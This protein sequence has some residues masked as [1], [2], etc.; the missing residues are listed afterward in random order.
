MTTHVNPSQYAIRN[1]H[2]CDIPAI[3]AMQAR[4]MWMLGGDFYTQ[5]EIATFM[6]A[7]GT[8]DDAIVLEGHFFV[9]EDLSGAILASGGWS[10]AKPG[11]A[12]ALPAKEPTADLPSVRSVFVDP[13]VARRGIGRTI[14]RQVEEDAIAHG[15]RLLSLT[16]TLSGVPLYER[17]EYQVEEAMQITFP[18][19]TR[20]GCVRM[21]KRLADRIGEQ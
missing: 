5:A 13:A 10:R 16:A 14:M 20:F 3:R 17:L 21:K 6:D 7:F 8:M 12:A 1:A 18:D 15:V 11:Y 9:A 4:S 2:A 19:Q